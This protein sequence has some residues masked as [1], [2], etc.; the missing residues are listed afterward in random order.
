[1]SLKI[2]E[3]TYAAKINVD[4]LNDGS[5]K[6]EISSGKDAVVKQLNLSSPKQENQRRIV[7]K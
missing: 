4:E 1:M 6:L 7:M 5:Y 3:M 2:N